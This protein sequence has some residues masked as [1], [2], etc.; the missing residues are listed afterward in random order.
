MNHF[1]KMCEWVLRLA[2]LNLLW[3]IFT[4]S[5]FVVMGFFPALAAAYTVAGEWVR[6]NTDIPVFQT[7]KTAYRKDF[8]KSQQLGYFFIAT[9]FV[10]IFYFYLLPDEA[11]LVKTLSSILVFAAVFFY[12]AAFLV[13]FPVMIRLRASFKDSMKKA[14]LF[15]VL[16]PFQLFACLAGTGFFAAAAAFFPGLLPFFCTS[17]PVLL[18]TFVTSKAFHS[19]TVKKDSTEAVH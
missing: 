17:L 5:G 14:L 11:S 15:A 3:I 19:L 12:A 2:Y 1:Y 10:L 4:V 8:W 9:G 13:I 6:G 18:V 7:F 16:K